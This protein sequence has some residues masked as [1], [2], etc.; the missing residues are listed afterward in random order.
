MALKICEWRLGHRMAQR[1]SAKNISVSL[2]NRTMIKQ[3]EDYLSKTYS[4][5]IHVMS[6][7][8]THLLSYF[9]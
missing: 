4:Q 3:W 9:I 6:F 2:L 5:I 8:S 1:F 7:I